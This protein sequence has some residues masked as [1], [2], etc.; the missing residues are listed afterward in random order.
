M[1]VMGSQERQIELRQLLFSESHLRSMENGNRKVTRDVAEGY[2]KALGTGGLLLD[3]L[4]ADEDGDDMRRRVVLS[5]LGTITGLGFAAPQIIAESLRESLLSA[6]GRDDWQ[7]VAAEYG[8]RFMSDPPSLFKSRLTGDLLVLRQTIVTRESAASLLAAPRLMMLHGMITANLGDAASAAR[9]YRA[10]RITA[11]GTRDMS[12]RQWV[13]G[14]EAF[15]RGY[16]GGAPHEVLTLASGVEEVEAKLAVAQAY[17]RLDQ[18][19]QA[20]AVLDEARRLHNTTD[21]SESTIYAM[22]AW[23]MA[24][25]SAYVYALLGDVTGCDNELSAVAPPGIVKRWEAQREIQRAVAYKRS[26]DIATGAVI[27]NKVMH[28][29]PDEECSIILNEMYREATSRTQSA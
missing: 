2:D 17:A 15:R 27:A 22:P 26:G 21:Q 7:E 1:G 19:A 24:L 13:R 5:V 25:S 29:T 18:S 9:W 3:L 6:I 16:E 10:A 4:I 23:R 12:L 11:D 28:D 8:Q 14:R 20:R